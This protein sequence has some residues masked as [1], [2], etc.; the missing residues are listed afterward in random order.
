M[1]SRIRDTV[2]M[3]FATTITSSEDS[4]V[5]TTARV[6]TGGTVGIPIVTAA[7]AAMG[8]D[9]PEWPLQPG[10][11]RERTPHPDLP[12]HRRPTVRQLVRRLEATRRPAPVW[13]GR[14]PT[15]GLQHHNVR[16]VLAVDNRCVKKE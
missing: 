4:I 8:P 9:N 5:G 15:A 1:C 11:P 2:G 14:V 16:I 6:R 13:A 12:A 10:R 3:R 7:I